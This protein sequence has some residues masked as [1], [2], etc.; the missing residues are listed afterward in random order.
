MNGYSNIKRSNSIKEWFRYHFYEKKLSSTPGV[1]LFALI[2][3]GIGFSSIT[4]DYRA[5]IGVLAIFILVFAF[6]LFMKY[7]YF[8]L[9]FLIVYS[10][11]PSYLG[12]IFMDSSIKIEFGNLID[13]LSILL[14]ISV[15]AKGKLQKKGGS[16]FWGNTMTTTLIILLFYYIIEALNPSMHSVL[17]WI[18]FI[19]K[20]IVTLLSFYALFCLLN[21]WKT[22]KFFIYFNIILTTMLAMYSCKQQWFGITNFEHRWATAS[23]ASYII[24]FQG[25]LLRK[26]ST[27]SD[28]GA[29]GVLFA[30]VAVQC[31]VLMLRI[32]GPKAKIWLSIAFIFNLL[33]Y[34]YSGTR[35]ATLMFIAGIAF[36][37]IAT[38]YEKRTL[39]FLVVSVVAFTGLMVMPYSPPSISRIKST[40]QG[41]KDL[42]AAVR[43]YNRH[44]VQPYLYKHPLGGGVFTSGAEGP[45]YNPGHY[46]VDFQPD[47]GYMKTFAEMG[48]IGLAILLITYFM[49]MSNGMHY[50]YQSKN[51]EFQNQTIGLLVML[52][53]LMVGQYSQIAIGFFP[54]ELYILGAMVI[55]VK[56]PFL[57]NEEIN[58]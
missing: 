53:S 37:G 14:F 19:R 1:F 20:Y 47:S 42:S 49:I 4:F 23:P 8:I 28:P 25:G 58:S 2:A 26:W 30:S 34:V 38:L 6:I 50:F 31:L 16:S 51:I 29:A 43:E 21:S 40:F 17:G 36:Y 45:K 15:I 33:G 56:L 5:G 22:I 52:F 41:N 44:N 46:L 3:I 55:F 18:S 7:P 11:F 13:V 27:L 10:K 12:R 32:K 35:T 54:Q 9:Y 57:E 39:V 24:L 48:F